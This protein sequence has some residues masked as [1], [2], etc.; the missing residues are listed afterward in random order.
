MKHPEP[1]VKNGIGYCHAAC[2]MAAIHLSDLIACHRG[3][4][5]LDGGVCLP[6]CEDLSM[7]VRHAIPLLK[8][9]EGVAT[10]LKNC[11]RDSETVYAPH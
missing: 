4:A 10:I 8:D 5:S 11:T 6:W 2:P 9:S 1:I 7:A 3:H